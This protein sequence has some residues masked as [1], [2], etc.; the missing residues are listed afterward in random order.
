G[1]FRED[2]YYRLAVMTIMLPRLNARGEDL[3]LLVG[4]FTRSFAA[5]AGKVI[6]RIS[7]HAL[8]LLKAH[9][10]SGNVRELRNVVE[11]ATILTT[12]D[13][14]RAEHLPDDFRGAIPKARTNS[15]QGS[16]TLVQL[17]SRHITQVLAQVGGQIGEAAE[18]LGIHRN[19]LARK[20]KEHGL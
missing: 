15:L 20:L 8:E 6:T 10:W 7:D 4:H 2:L 1:R 12:G 19:T 3:L 17:E 5:R 13:T 18:L 14:I 16:L 9:E 11:R